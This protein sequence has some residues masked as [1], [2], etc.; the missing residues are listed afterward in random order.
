MLNTIHKK[1]LICFWQNKNIICYLE[2]IVEGTMFT[3]YISHGI[4]IFDAMP[5]ISYL[6][7]SKKNSLHVL[8][9]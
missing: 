2:I 6:G 8:E 7:C 5:I 4:S 3:N 1:T 9:T